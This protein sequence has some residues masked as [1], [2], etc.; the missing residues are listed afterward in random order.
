MIDKWLWTTWEQAGLVVVSSVLIFVVVVV[1]T[2][3][4]GLRTFSKMSSF[5]FAITVATGSVIA[6]VAVT[7]SSLT[8]GAIALAT[9]YVCQYGV[10]QLR[11]RTGFGPGLVDNNPIVLMI[12]GELI[13]K[14]L[15]HARVTRNDV[16]AKLRANGVTRVADVRAVILETTGD[17]SVLTGDGSIDEALLVDVRGFDAQDRIARTDIDQPVTDPERATGPS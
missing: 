6:T 12:D 1:V 13:E 14:N 3:V 7:S 17:V 2:R 16:L 8:N 11:R 9:I 10:A 5:D 4:V 15:T